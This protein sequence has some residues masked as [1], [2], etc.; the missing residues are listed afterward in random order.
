MYTLYKKSQ[1][2]INNVKKFY[3]NNLKPIEILKL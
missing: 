3:I 2:F 1:I